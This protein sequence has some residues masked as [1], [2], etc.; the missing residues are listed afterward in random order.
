M[1]VMERLMGSWPEDEGE[2][3]VEVGGPWMGGKE[4]LL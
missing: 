2:K 4:G 3:R 1:G